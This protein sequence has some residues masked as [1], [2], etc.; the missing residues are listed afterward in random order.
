MDSQ[1]YMWGG[2]VGHSL[3]TQLATNNY[4]VIRARNLVHLFQAD[5]IY[6]VVYVLE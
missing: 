5:G 4:C 2:A 6:L 1:K 3:K